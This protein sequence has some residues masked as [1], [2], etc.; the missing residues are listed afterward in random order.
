MFFLLTNGKFKHPML[1]QPQFNWKK[2]YA[3]P[4]ILKNIHLHY[5]KYCDKF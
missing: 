2:E 1:E 3:K 5:K 4:K